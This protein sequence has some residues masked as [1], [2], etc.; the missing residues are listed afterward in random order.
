MTAEPTRETLLQHLLNQAVET[1]CP[2][3]FT[4]KLYAEEI[5]TLRSHSHAPQP[6]D[7]DTDWLRKF[8]LESWEVVPGRPE[9]GATI[10]RDDDREMLLDIAT[11]ISQQAQRIEELEGE[12][13]KLI[14]ADYNLRC[15]DCGGAHFLDTSIPSVI[16]NQIAPD[17]GMLCTLCIDR[18]MAAKGLKCDEAEFYFVGDN[19]Q[20]K[21]Y[22]ESHGEVARLERER[23]QQADKIKRLEE[24]LVAA[25]YDLVT[26]HNLWACDNEEGHS[27]FQ[28]DQIS[29]PKVR[30]ALTGET[31]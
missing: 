4:L 21:L 18:R 24:A 15:D 27:L 20:S 26:S 9:S 3:L 5:A 16:W 6:A 12:R 22:A 2:G 13:R 29:L 17:G 30:A 25:E 7:G 8:C 11:R 28:I 14:R 23:D 10:L 19:L 1:D 31:Q